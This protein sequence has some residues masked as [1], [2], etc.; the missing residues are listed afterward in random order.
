M[1]LATTLTELTD[2]E[3]ALAQSILRPSYEI[4]PEAV[5]VC[6][7]VVHGDQERH[8]EIP[9]GTFVEVIAA[10]GLE[11]MFRK[12]HAALSTAKAALTPDALPD[13]LGAV[14]STDPGPA[15]QDCAFCHRERNAK[16]NNH[17]PE[18]PYWTIGPG[19]L[20]TGEVDK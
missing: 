5:R 10:L 11:R 2:E 12:F 4:N 1:R 14:P 7:T 8:V 3:W 16:D 9:L 6:L 18:C 17:A 20:S 13:D 15:R 19:S